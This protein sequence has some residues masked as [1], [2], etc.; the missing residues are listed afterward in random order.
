MRALTF[1][2]LGGYFLWFARAM[3]LRGQVTIGRQVWPL[4]LVTRDDDPI[5]FRILLCFICAM[6][7]G[8]LVAALVSAFSK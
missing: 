7:S 4:A 2:L 6:G 1:A 5:T 8:L 3:F